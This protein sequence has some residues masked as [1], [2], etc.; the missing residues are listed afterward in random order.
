[1]LEEGVLKETSEFFTI[2]KLPSDEEIQEIIKEGKKE[3]IKYSNDPNNTKYFWT[4]LHTHITPQITY[5]LM[6]IRP[7]FDGGIEFSFHS[8]VTAVYVTIPPEDRLSIS[9]QIDYIPISGIEPTETKKATTYDYKKI[10][11]CIYKET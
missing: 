5:W 9:Y 7:T 10:A 1:L 4:H 8:W 2:T 11:R 6:D 3:Q